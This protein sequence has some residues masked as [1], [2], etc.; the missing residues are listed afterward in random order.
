M[1]MAVRRVHRYS[2]ESKGG[3]NSARRSKRERREKLPH[4]D[5]SEKKGMF[6]REE[7]AEEKVPTIKQI[8]KII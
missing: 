4:A 7:S 1:N 6:G 5:C 3:D 8:Q 2:V